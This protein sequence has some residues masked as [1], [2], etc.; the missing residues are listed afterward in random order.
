MLSPLKPADDD[1]RQAQIQAAR[2]MGDEIDPDGNPDAVPAT[3]ATLT[4]RRHHG[5]GGGA[6]RGRTA[7][8][9][10]RQ[11]TL[12]GHEAFLKALEFSGAV[13]VVEKISDGSKIRGVLKHSDKFTLTLRVEDKDGETPVIRERVIFKHDISEFYSLTPRPDTGPGNHPRW[14]EPA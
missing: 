1:I 12:R 11:V 8:P 6:G 9:P 10:P 7:L 4:L 3:R 13:L 2:Q 5:P 14:V